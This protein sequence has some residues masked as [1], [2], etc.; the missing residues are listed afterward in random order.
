MD[1]GRRRQ[2]GHHL[3]EVLSQVKGA[4]WAGVTGGGVKA[5]NLRP[6]LETSEES[7]AIWPA[8]GFH[9]LH[10]FE[11]WPD[12]QVNIEAPKGK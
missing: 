8:L 10:S 4:L 7:P 5:G 11:C 12:F 1:A 6:R 3:R 9:S 2:V